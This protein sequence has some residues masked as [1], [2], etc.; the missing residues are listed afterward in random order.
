MIFHLNQ[1]SGIPVYLQLMEQIKHGVE[2]GALH[3]GEQ[4][5]TIRKLAADLVINPNTVVRA[6]RELQHAGVVELRQGSGAYVREPVEERSGVMHRASKLA[7]ALVERLSALGLSEQEIR[8][9]IESELTAARNK[10][11]SEVA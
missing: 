5:P 7:N 3:A 10:N 2:T 11:E 4:L 8:R 1:S 9:I 6:Y